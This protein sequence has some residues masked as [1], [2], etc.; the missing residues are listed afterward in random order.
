VKTSIEL[1]LYHPDGA[2]A[3]IVDYEEDTARIVLNKRSRCA[4]DTCEEAA[5]VLR[6][7]ALRFELL[8]QEEDPFKASTQ[9]KI[10]KIQLPG[11]EGS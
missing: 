10:N 6:E 8:A 7:L 4:K 9:D 2:V 5:K 11:M 3:N 1:A